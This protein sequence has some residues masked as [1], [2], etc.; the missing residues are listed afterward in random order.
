MTR[1][2]PVNATHL[3][4]TL[5]FQRAHSG[6]NLGEGA[7]IAIAMVPFLLA[8]ILFSWFGLQ[9]RKW[10][11]G[12]ERRLRRAA[13]AIAT[14][15]AHDHRRRRAWTT[16]HAAAQD[17]HGLPAARAS[18]SSCCC[19]RSTGW[20]SPPSSRTSSSSTGDVQ[21]VLGG[22][23]DARRTSTSCCSI[24]PIR[25]WLW[26]TM[27][28][29]VAATVPVARSP[30]CSPPMR[31]SACAS[32]GRAVGAGDLPRLSRAAVDPVHP[33]R[34][35]VF[36]LRPVRHPLRA[37]PHLPDVPDPVLAPGC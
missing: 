3:M 20:R 37:D 33:A 36:Q 7:A 2:G 4:A 32:A 28:V 31:S 18:S 24:P 19:S 15:T 22:R 17:R 8:A 25:D 6:G 30:A 9:R 10:Q 1:G 23:A 13:T 14:A 27:L 35:I 21:P 34:D 11:Q 16:R 12:G 29:S 5:S 26:N